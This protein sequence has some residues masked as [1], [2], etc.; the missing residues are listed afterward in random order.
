MPPPEKLK[1]TEGKNTS[2]ALAHDLNNILAANLMHLG[3]LRQTPGLAEETIQSINEMEGETKRAVKLVRELLESNKPEIEDALTSNPPIADSSEEIIGGGTETI[4]LVEDE[5]GLRRMMALQ[6]RKLGYA[7]LE[8]S[9]SP[10]ALE[11]WERSEGKIHLLLTDMTMAGGMN[12]LDLAQNMRSK[13]PSLKV[14]LLSGY[15]TKSTQ[16]L[17]RLGKEII[18]LNKPCDPGLLEKSVRACLDSNGTSA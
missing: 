3:F 9:H 14:I 17:S 5:I 6:L 8:A 4:L 11:Q 12:G 1:S 13:N 2:K 16:S 7:V 18:Y 10:E 15:D